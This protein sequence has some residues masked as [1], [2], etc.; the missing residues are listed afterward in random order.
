[1]KTFRRISKN[2]IFCSLM[3]LLVL[4]STGC[5]KEDIAST[6][7]KNNSAEQTG[8]EQVYDNKSTESYSG[9]DLFKGIFFAKG[10]VAE[11]LPA[12]RNSFSYDIIRNM[13]DEE[14]H[15]AEMKM[16]EILDRL[17]N[18]RPGYFDE[19][20]ELINTRDHLLISEGL[21]QATQVL[22]EVSIDLFLSDQDK[23]DLDRIVADINMEEHTN[24]DGSI[25]FETLRA[26]VLSNMAGGNERA[27]C[28]FA[29]VVFVAA[30]YVLVVHAAAAMTYVAV[31]WVAE[32]YAAVDQEK[33]ITRGGIAS[34][35]LTEELLVRDIGAM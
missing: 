24:E 32:F 35:H 33:T 16:N 31:A 19:F 15:Q 5:T 1:M 25:N 9:R 14:N 29:G 8:N 6:I 4:F 28:V 21:G 30:A 2:P 20:K 10:P 12:I 18:S 34:G 22:Y 11:A 27:L 26:D 17:E 7:A 13:T 23:A 3:I